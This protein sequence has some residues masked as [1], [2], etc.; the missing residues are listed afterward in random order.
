MT[1][2]EARLIPEGAEVELPGGHR[3]KLITRSSKRSGPQG[4]YLVHAGGA[5]YVYKVYGPRCSRAREWGNRLASVLEGRSAPDPA[6]RLDVERRA[7]RLWRQHGF[8]VFQEAGS[9]PE[10]PFGAPTLALEYVPG[11]S[12]QDYFADKAVPKG[13]K[14][15]ALRRLVAEGA[16]RNDLAR[17]LNEPLLVHEYPALVHIW[18]GDDGVFRH[19]DFEVVFTRRRRIE[20]LIAREILRYTRSVLR[21]TPEADRAEFLEVILEHYPHREFLRMAY[22]DPWRSP[23]PAVRIF[24]FFERHARRGRQP[25]SRF[26][27][28]RRIAERLDELPGKDDRAGQGPAPTAR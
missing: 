25:L 7:L 5:D 20:H 27:V 17:R 15:E 24:R 23:N 9:A 14:L 10:I 2:L 3:G 22:R 13:E 21:A 12:A 18:R 6:A 8:A 11:R 26:A 4:I 16:R 28:A 19:F 1:P